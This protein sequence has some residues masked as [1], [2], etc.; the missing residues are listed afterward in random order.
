MKWDSADAQM[1]TR[2]SS[3]RRLPNDRTCGAPKEGVLRRFV[4]GRLAWGEGFGEAR[5]FAPVQRAGERV[6]HLRS[7][8][9]SSLMLLAR[10]GRPR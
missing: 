2:C 4:H 1:T 7:F 3:P 10:F 6:E 5:H 8:R 9:L